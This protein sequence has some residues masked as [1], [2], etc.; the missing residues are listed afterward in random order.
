MIEGLFRTLAETQLEK[1]RQKRIEAE[2]RAQELAEA[3]K[4]RTKDPYQVRLPSGFGQP[5]RP[6]AQPAQPPR[7]MSINV[8][9]RDVAQYAENLVKFNQQIVPLVNDLRTVSARNS[10]IRGL[11]PEA[12]G[13]M[14][15][16]RA[17]LKS[18]D[19]LSRLDSVVNPYRDLDAGQAYPDGPVVEK[20]EEVVPA[21]YNRNSKLRDR[22]SVV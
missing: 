6:A 11:M 4:S 14:A 10:A 3:E 12:Y 15:D 19:G 7:N 9:S 16:T 13:V 21:R 20:Y 18:C 5:N 8:R 22:K 1:E 17:I 2:R